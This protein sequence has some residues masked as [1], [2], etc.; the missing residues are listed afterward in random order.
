MTLEVS[1]FVGNFVGDY[2]V[3]CDVGGTFTDCIVKF[4]DGTKSCLKVLSSGKIKGRVHGWREPGC[5]LDP[6][7]LEA[8]D[9]F[10]DGAA[11]RWIGSEG[12]ILATDRCR[13]SLKNQGWMQ[14]ESSDAWTS[15]DHELRVQYEI[16]CGLQAPVLAARLIL[17]CLPTEKLPSMRVRLG[18]TRGTNALLTRT[19]EPCALVTSQ[20]FTDLVRIGYQE[21]PELF[22]LN[23]RKRIPLH[24]QV[25]EIDERLDASGKVLRP[26]DLE[27]TELRLKDLYKSGIRSIAI[28]LLHSYCNPIHELAV[29]A[30]AKGI[31]FPC[32]CVSS[33]IAPRIKA[34]SRAETTLVDAYLTP[35]VQQYLNQVSEQFG[36]EHD[37][38][39]RILTSAGGL[40]ASNLYRGKDSV[41]SGPAGGA[42]AIEAYS[43]AFTIPKCIGLDMGGT[44]TDVCRIDGSIQLEQETV[45]AGV[46]MMTPTLAIH[47]V[48]AGGGSVCWFDGVQLR[49]GPQSAG[50]DP[51]PACYG[52]GGPLTIT[53]LNLLAGRISESHFPFPLDRDAASRRLQ[54]V[55]ATMLATIP[56]GATLFSEE[57][58]CD[59]FRR[60]ANEHMA[61]AVRSISISQGADPREHSLL[62]FG[63]AAGQHICEIA[64]LLGIQHVIDPPEAGLL[65]ALGMGMAS[66]QR[67]I[68]RPIYATLGTIE[69]ERW[70]QVLQSIREEARL[71]FENER[72]EWSI[73]RESIELELKY[74]G[75]EGS[76][77][78]SASH[79]LLS[80]D[81]QIVGPLLSTQFLAE[82]QNRFGYVRPGKDMEV[83]SIK[84]TYRVPAENLPEQI[85]ITNTGRNDGSPQGDTSADNPIQKPIVIAQRHEL[86]PGSKLAGPGL[87][88]SQGSTTYIDEGWIA[89]VL[90]DRTLS[91]TR[92]IKRSVTRSVALEVKKHGSSDSDVNASGE[93][94]DPVLREVLAQRI[95]A[96]AD[97]MGIV[98]EQT[99][100][101]VNV[102][103]RRD[104]SCAVF[105]G[106]GDLIA[107]APHVPVHLGAMSET[108]RCM[109]KHYPDM[110]DGDCYITNDPYQGGSHL[111]DITVI[112]PIMVPS[113]LGERQTAS[114]GVDFFVACRAHHAEIGG[115]CPGSMSPTSNQLGQEGVIIPPMKLVDAGRNCMEDVERLL[116]ESKYPS[117]SVSENLADLAA[118]QAANQRGRIAMIELADRYEVHVLKQYL[119]H[120]QAASERKTQVWIRSLGTS[121]RT[122]SDR[123][124]DGT[125]IVVSMEPYLDQAGNPK[126]RVDFT[127]SGAV[128]LGNLNANPAIVSA[129]TMYA[130]R[131]ALSDS[132]P[133][134]SGVLRCVEFVIPDGILNPGRT[135]LQANWPAVAGGN[136]ETSQRIVDCLL[137]ALGLAA[138]SQ[139]T[140]NNFLFGDSQFGY[141][142]TIGGGT[143]ATPMGDGEHA[144]HSHMTNTRLTDVE[145]LEK[146]YPVRL[147]RFGIRKGSGGLGRYTG[148]DGMIRQVQALRPLEVSLVTSRRNSSPFGLEQAS[149]GV[150][151]ENW[152][153]DLDGAS[154]RLESSV[155]LML[156]AGESILILT[157]GGGGFG[158]ALLPPG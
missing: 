124:D 29:E 133:L 58:L 6:D 132:L 151:G 135:G 59:G 66:V 7:R 131:C 86:A 23:V 30:I 82:H 8:P 101:S 5:F 150:P 37:T 77:M 73:P 42:V 85:S 54:E 62:G 107:N 65:S 24:A 51:G 91:V 134:N 52:R 48:A 144:V 43:K 154:H 148:G 90:S 111:P 128:S 97:Q 143:G 13:R 96:I 130:I 87:I 136:V 49:V 47:T 69:P 126:L 140:M 157:P 11:V 156:Q 100:M 56:A 41:L 112:T 155:Q 39:L 71:A 4:P 117:R 125:K 15:S 2:Q 10:W 1:S 31:G 94:V 75:T 103:D 158:K 3:W 78:V 147:I 68:S 64:D 33:R 105:A 122:F 32:I 121:K 89:E 146:R 120:I 63:G 17:G 20:G 46:R 14:L 80:Q 129:A 106:N 138:A 57:D 19:G 70:Q 113:L 9:H 123:M 26:I 44:S 98:L 25:L 119:K 114:G 67:A 145:V 36:L 137:G 99:A 81:A 55:L 72:I 118:Q 116:R 102:K 18:T 108:I 152:R 149:A 21:R 153:V 28:C 142:E 95:A 38:D 35:V 60:L 61:A 104:F 83:C 110:Q 27:S 79:S 141:Y 93:S 50:A 92:S 109:L 115:I 40:V 16:D 45:K 53:D 139:G 84:C 34:V 76:L 88:V 12:Q 127:G 74:T 22:D